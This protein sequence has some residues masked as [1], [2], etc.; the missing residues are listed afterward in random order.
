MPQGMR[1][2][3]CFG[4]RPK[5]GLGG[6]VD[7]ITYFLYHINNKIK[8]EMISRSNIKRGFTLIEL[9]VSMGIVGS[10][11]LVNA[12]EGQFENAQIN[13]RAMGVEIF[14]YNSAVSRYLAANSADP[15]A[16]G[17]TPSTDQVYSG[18][19]WLKDPS[20]AGSAAEAYLAC[21][22]MADGRTLQYDSLPTTTISVNADGALRARTVW[23]PAFGDDGDEDAMVMGTAS[24][25]ASGSYFSQAADAASG[26]QL[27]TVYCPDM[28]TY[29]P[30]IASICG[31]ER[32]QIVSMSNTNSALEPWLRTDHG[33]TSQH[34]IEFGSSPSAQSDLDLVDDGGAV[35][36]WA[37]AGMRQ[38]VNVARIYNQGGS[39]QDAVVI[40]KSAGKP[41][42]SDAFVTGN[43]LL[44]NAIIMDGDAAVMEDLR[45]K[46][47]AYIDNDLAVGRD[48]SVGQD[49]RVTRDINSTTGDITADSGD[50][51]ADSGTVRGSYVRSL[52]DVE[53]DR[54]VRAQRYNYA[55]RYYDSDNTSFYGDPSSRS[56]VNSITASGDI[57]APIFYDQNDTY[58][59]SNPSATSRVNSVDVRNR[60]TVRNHVNLTKSVNVGWGCSPSGLVARTGNGTLASCVSGVWRTAGGKMTISRDSVFGRTSANTT[61]PSS[62]YIGVHSFCTMNGILH[63]AGSS[64]NIHVLDVRRG[65]AVGDKFRWYYRNGAESSGTRV[66]VMCYNM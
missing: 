3:C 57:R 60:L 59:Y 30:S 31:S 21:E 36:G 48:A 5:E 47:D 26:F 63:Y 52:G 11:A 43:G 9:A 38:I 24:M 16:I 51:I 37:G 17:V 29:S 49:L 20:C 40:G 58:Y 39:G 62:L 22:V 45:V 35:G 10:L 53:A 23:T 8:N 42:Y 25:V 13:A 28:T 50:V 14:Q 33:N 54:D 34:V 4:C 18:S 41:I 7:T 56:Q 64:D 65:S 55:Q 12:Q 6:R 2:F 46:L 66:R 1:R 15:S 44:Q 32:N 61:S 27:P 19:D